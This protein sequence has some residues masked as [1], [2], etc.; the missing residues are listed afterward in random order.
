MH[1]ATCLDNDL[2]RESR[3]WRY[4]R[5]KI[6]SPGEF[7]GLA[8]G[9]GANVRFEN[10][11]PCMLSIAQSGIR[12]K[13]SRFGLLGAVLYDEANAFINA[14]RTGALA[15]LFPDTLFP[16]EISNPNLRAFF[17]AILHCRNAAEVSV[18]LNQAIELAEKRAGCK[19]DE[20]SVSGFPPWARSS[21]GAEKPTTPKTVDDVLSV[22]GALLERYPLAV[23]NVAMLPILKKQMKVLLKGLYAKAATA[24]LQNTFEVGFHLLSHFQEGVGATPIDGRTA[25]AGQMEAK[26]AILKKWMPWN[27]LAMAE[28]KVLEA[29]WNRFL[30]GEPI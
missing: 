19:F 30:A 8:L 22:Y 15:Y 25:S 21:S 7:S 26:M 27:T 28:A 24:D 6:L 2:L 17:N 18:T 5:R 23:M 20:M 10:G 12:V 14:R 16:N 4:S 1:I 13:K 3:S 11:E 9:C 29:E